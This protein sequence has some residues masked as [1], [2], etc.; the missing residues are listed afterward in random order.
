MK[1]KRFSEATRYDAPITAVFMGLRLQGFEPDGSKNQWVESR[2]S[3]LV[4]A[5]APILRPSRR[6]MS[7]WW[8]A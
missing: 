4:A 1:V 8:A 7:A 3:S 6:F 5:R 2:I